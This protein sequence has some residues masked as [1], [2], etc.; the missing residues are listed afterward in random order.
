MF[1]L[2]AVPAI[3]QIVGLAF[4]PE[5]PRYLLSFERE[6]QEGTPSTPNAFEAFEALSEL[7]PSG[8]DVRAECEQLKSQLREQ[9]ADRGQL[10]ILFFSATV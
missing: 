1:G 5:S 2:G 3:L 7:R 9:G 10:K 8:C 4:L 6:E